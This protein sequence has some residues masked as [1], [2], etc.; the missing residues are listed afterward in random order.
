VIGTLEPVARAADGDTSDRGRERR[1]S[2]AVDAAIID[3]ARTLFVVNGYDGAS[4]RDIAERA[5]VSG[6]MIYRRFASKAELFEVAVLSPFIEAVEGFVAQASL[7][8]AGPPLDVVSAWFRPMYRLMRENRGLIIGLL[9]EDSTAVER[10]P[11][12]DGLRKILDEGVR[13]AARAA[14]RRG[15]RGID[16][17]AEVMV[18]L[19]M[20]IGVAALEGL[21]GGEAVALEPERVLEEM[22]NMVTFGQYRPLSDAGSQTETVELPRAELQRL[23]DDLAAAEGRAVRAEQQ[24]RLLTTA[25]PGGARLS[26]APSGAT[27]PAES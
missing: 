14:E 7:D 11:L 16:T 5:G 2:A 13:G 21:F 4:M 22:I 23:I 10:S 24:L 26:D 8:L 12:G 20:V 9:A 17:E 25:R 19:G 18:G 27:P 15:L 6:P 3:S 1:S